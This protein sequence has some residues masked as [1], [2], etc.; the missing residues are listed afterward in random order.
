M[1]KALVGEY[2]A[3]GCC[4]CSRC[5]LYKVTEKKI[6]EQLITDIHVYGDFTGVARMSLNIDPDSLKDY[7]FRFFLAVQAGSLSHVWL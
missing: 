2:G 1:H 5:L 6:K 3:K 7:D 4:S